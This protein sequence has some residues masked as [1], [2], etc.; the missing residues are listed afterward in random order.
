MSNKIKNKNFLESGKIWELPEE[1]R[2]CD[3]SINSQY[4]TNMSS[5]KGK[6]KIS[7]RYDRKNAY[8]S[9]AIA[10]YTENNKNK[11]VF[12]S[13]ICK[14]NFAFSKKANNLYNELQDEADKF[15]EETGYNTAEYWEKYQNLKYEY[16]SKEN[17]AETIS[18]PIYAEKKLKSIKS[19][20]NHEVYNFRYEYRENFPYLFIPNYEEK[21]NKEISN[22]YK[23][24]QHLEQSNGYNSN[25]NI[26]PYFLRKQK[27]IIE[28]LA[29]MI[30]IHSK[31]INN[32]EVMSW[33]KY[34]TKH[35]IALEMNEWKI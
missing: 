13:Y 29:K 31:I 1:V 28:K 12:I 16:Q 34:I 21:V 15:I 26:I 8:D 4:I 11:K 6:G 23:L 27:A 19:A 7:A 5:H 9:E 32:E 20:I 33:Y 2:L 22:Q 24:L 3:K 25:K 14:N 10:I 30:Q 17:W 18:F 35:K